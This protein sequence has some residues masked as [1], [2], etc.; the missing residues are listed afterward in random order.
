M[1]LGPAVVA[2]VILSCSG[3]AFA[4]IKN[5]S[6]TATIKING[7]DFTVSGDYPATI[8]G[9][10]FMLGKGMAYQA[11]AGEYQITIASENRSTGT[12]PLNT[13][14]GKDVN[15]MVTL[16]GKGKSLVRHPAN[17]GKLIVSD[18]YKKAEATLELRPVVGRG[19]TTLNATFICK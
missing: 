4:Q 15:V 5:M 18:D 9:G 12:V 11:K 13:A 14:D 16:N 8:C 1:K 10:P 17:G 3:A 6:G 7:L 19:T 2:T